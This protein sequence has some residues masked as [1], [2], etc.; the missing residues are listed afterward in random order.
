[1]AYL[2]DPETQTVTKV[3]YDG[4]LEQAYKLI[5][6]DLVEQV[7][8]NNDNVLIVDE[9]GMF[10]KKHHFT[11]KG[12]PQWIAGKAI[13]VGADPFIWTRPPSIPIHE[14]RTIIFFKQ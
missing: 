9:E 14:V 11:I 4:S 12:Y 5:G 13:M 2:I 3:E 7:H 6:C 1:M 8:L 10:F